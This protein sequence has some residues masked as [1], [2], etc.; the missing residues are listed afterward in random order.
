MSA[1][2]LALLLQ[3]APSHPAPS[4]TPAASHAQPAEAPAAGAHE[5]ATEAHPSAA[6]SHAAEAGESGHEAESCRRDHASRD[7]RAVHGRLRLEAHGVPVPG[8]GAGDRDRAARRA[9]LPRRPDPARDRRRGREPG[10]LHPRRGGRAE[11]RPRRRSQVHAAAVQ[12]LLLHPGRRRSSGL[13]ALLRHL[14]RQHRGDARARDSS[15]SPPSSGPGSRSTASRA[16]S[17]T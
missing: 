10:R 12:L 5:T 8:S 4:A 15:P 11:H 1:L 16:T 13:L 6:E 9:Q 3:A 7:G 14:D 17:T 2:L